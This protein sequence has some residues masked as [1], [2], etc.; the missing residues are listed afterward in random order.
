MIT[1]CAATLAMHTAS[2]GT[3]PFATGTTLTAEKSISLNG[4]RYKNELSTTVCDTLLNVAI[5]DTPAI[6]QW[7][8]P[9]EGYLSGNGSLG[10]TTGGTP[11]YFPIT[12][13]GEGYTLPSTGYKVSVADVF[14]GIVTI[15]GADSAK[16]V[17]AYVYDSTGTGFFGGFAPGNRID[18][19]TVT[20]RSIAASVTNN[21]PSVFAFTHQPALTSRNFFVVVAL[22]QVTGDTLV[23]LTNK[24]T[25]GRGNGF[26][27]VPTAGPGGWVSYDSLTGRKQGDFIIVQACKTT[28]GIESVNAGVA[29]FSVSPNPSNGV[30]TAAINLESASDVTITVIDIT[31]S[32]IYESTEASV[33]AINKQ[34]NLSSAASGLYFVSVRTATGSVNQRIVIK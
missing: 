5:T 28:T 31:G 26:I 3:N 6:Y 18:S 14:F 4:Q 1:V 9:S 12:A 27:A 16:L 19:A 23:V 8:F 7:R 24:N 13:V 29:D 25:T 32:K 2:A 33:K 17:T 10:D 22:P 30:F 20:L 15:N 21:A 34:I 11:A